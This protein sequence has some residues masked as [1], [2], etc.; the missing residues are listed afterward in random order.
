M[1][2]GSDGAHVADDKTVW[3]ISRGSET[4][5]KIPAL[6]INNCSQN[7]I[8]TSGSFVWVLN[9]C[10]VKNGSASSVFSSL[11]L[12]NDPKTGE[13]NVATLATVGDGGSQLLINRDKVWVNTDF[14]NVVDKNTLEIRTFRPDRAASL[15]PLSGNAHRVYLVAAGSDAG[16]QFVIAIDPNTLKETA[17]GATLDKPIVNMI[18]DEQNVIAF[19]QDEIYVLSASDLRLERVIKTTLIQFHADAALILNGDL[20]VADGELGV[21]IPNRLLLFHNWRLPAAPMPAPK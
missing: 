15:G 13:R 12:R 10:E 2:L 18:A 6:G 14:C 7:K 11:L 5:K 21:D 3:Q 17:R 16:P 9:S 19:G 1:G 8:V 20:L 4:L